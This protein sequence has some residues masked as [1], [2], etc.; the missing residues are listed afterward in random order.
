MRGVK[1]CLS[2]IMF[3]LCCCSE[4][5]GICLPEE[6]ERVHKMMQ[7]EEKPYEVYF[8]ELCARNYISIPRETTGV[9]TLSESPGEF[10]Q[11]DY[12]EYHVNRSAALH[13]IL[14]ADTTIEQKAA[15]YAAL[16]VHKPELAEEWL[17][18]VLLQYYLCDKRTGDWNAP[19]PYT[20]QELLSMAEQVF[21]TPGINW[22]A[23]GYNKRTSAGVLFRFVMAAPECEPIA[24]L[25][26]RYASFDEIVYLYDEPAIALAAMA[27]CAE[28]VRLLL[29]RGR[30]TP[31]LA[32]Y[33]V[34]RMQYS[35]GCMQTAQNIASDYCRDFY[36]SHDGY[37]RGRLRMRD[38]ENMRS[39]NHGA[40]I[41]QQFL[42]L[43]PADACETVAAPAP[44][45]EG[46]F[47]VQEAYTGMLQMC[48]R[49]LAPFVCRKKQ[50]SDE[51][52]ATTWRNQ[53]DT[54]ESP[55]YEHLTNPTEAEVEQAVADMES[56]LRAEAVTSIYHPEPDEVNQR[57]FESAYM[58][59]C[60]IDK[61]GEMPAC[62]QEDS[63]VFRLLRDCD[64]L[65]YLF[66]ETAET[67]FAPE[68][69]EEEEIIL[70][71]EAY[72]F[73]QD[74]CNDMT[75]YCHEKW[76]ELIQQQTR[77]VD[78]ALSLQLQGNEKEVHIVV[79]AAEPKKVLAVNYVREGQGDIPRNPVLRFVQYVPISGK[80]TVT[81]DAAHTAPVI[82]CDDSFF[83]GEEG[84]SP[85]P[86]FVDHLGK[87]VRCIDY[88]P[89]YANR[90][91][92]D[93]YYDGTFTPDG[94]F[95]EGLDPKPVLAKPLRIQVELVP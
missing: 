6:R 53:D 71:E 15:D 42:P 16:L 57:M 3:V 34:R 90:D 50:E 10:E 72:D 75:Y 31:E 82:L 36:Y 68:D 41:V 27:D 46:D 44:V 43:I 63:A 94:S 47:V 64:S 17:E 59:Y 55:S 4:L 30:V 45:W 73:A 88:Q 81:I 40:E 83:C 69:E 60:Y 18:I 54:D 33:C 35:H 39:K 48:P 79:S 26:C 5:W 25:F 29:A 70:A 91:E 21:R 86:E 2:I 84:A 92:G 65:C 11:L 12:A 19:V 62:V 28:S 80:A 23:R 77:C 76:F 52:S 1:T 37:S 66:G 32:A 87:H 49:L 61:H 22:D 74:A 9:F 93:I 95:A 7:E 56:F 67:A 8:S 58:L 20:R 85:Y 24:D 14:I 51:D 13:D 78:I 89:Y 38:T